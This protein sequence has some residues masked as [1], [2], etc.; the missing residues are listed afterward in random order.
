MGVGFLLKNPGLGYWM[1][2]PS[3]VSPRTTPFHASLPYFSLK[4]SVSKLMLS[5]TAVVL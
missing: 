4:V 1:N 5:P 2:V 3:M